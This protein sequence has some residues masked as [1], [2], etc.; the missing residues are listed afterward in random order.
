[1]MSLHSY[2]T[3][4]SVTILETKTKYFASSA[5]KFYF[6]ISFL[7]SNQEV[8]IS[9]SLVPYGWIFSKIF[10]LY[11]FFRMRTSLN[12]VIDLLLLL[13]KIPLLIFKGPLKLILFRLEHIKCSGSR[14]FIHIIFSPHKRGLFRTDTLL[15][16][17]FV[18]SSERNFVHFI[19]AL[20]TKMLPHHE[21]WQYTIVS[22]FWSGERSRIII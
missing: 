6:L 12:A 16:S 7:S 8:T 15:S 13:F 17:L 20:A 9:H 4:N 11:D 18:I 1:M 21:H 3:K 19:C 22:H 14:N 5:H 2:R 10:N